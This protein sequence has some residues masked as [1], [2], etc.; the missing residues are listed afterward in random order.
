MELWIDAGYGI[1]F[2]NFILDEEETK[3][4]YRDVTL[5]DQYMDKVFNGKFRQ[6]FIE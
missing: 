2:V 3:N 5:V 6:I 4:F 1:F